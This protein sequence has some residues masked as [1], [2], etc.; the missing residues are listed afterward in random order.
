MG[1]QAPRSRRR[2]RSS[3]WSLMSRMVLSRMALLVRMILFVGM[4]RMMF[5]RLSRMMRSSSEQRCCSSDGIF[6]GGRC[7]ASET[8]DC[9]VAVPLTGPS[10]AA[11]HARVVLIPLHL[12]LLQAAGGHVQPFFK[13][14]VH[15]AIRARAQV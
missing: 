1:W 10:R 8:P 4:S 15:I 13:E 3:A 12:Q 6:L 2:R 7:M 11:A 14:R 9:A 5:A